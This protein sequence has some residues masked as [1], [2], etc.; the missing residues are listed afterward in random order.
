MERWEE[1]WGEGEGSGEL[2]TSGPLM[3]S[4]V[5]RM[6]ELGVEGWWGECAAR[7][8][9]RWGWEWEEGVERGKEGGG[10]VVR[11]WAGEP[12]WDEKAGDG[13]TAEAAGDGRAED[14]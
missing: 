10:G 12:A 8:G 14:G 4:L 7:L 9:V 2:W 5:H 13:Y 11:W 6:W 3:R 1:G